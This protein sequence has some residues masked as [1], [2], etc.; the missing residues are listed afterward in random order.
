VVRSGC[1]HSGDWS[2]LPRRPRRSFGNASRQPAPLRCSQ[3][4][5]A[6]LTSSRREPSIESVRQVSK[7]LRTKCG[8][9]PAVDRRTET[10]AVSARRAGRSIAPSSESGFAA[11]RAVLVRPLRAVTLRDHPSRPGVPT[12]LALF[13]RWWPSILQP[14]C[15]RRWRARCGIGPPCPTRRP[16]ASSRWC[17]DQYLLSLR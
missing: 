8:L 16:A 7:V 2:R 1:P 6:L 3:F 5:R 17:E 4:E 13:S 15:R 11:D 12:G 10:A 9:R 14:S